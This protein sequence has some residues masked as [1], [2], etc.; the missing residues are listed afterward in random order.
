MRR[1]IFV[2]IVLMS[3]PALAQ[4]SSGTIIVFNLTQDKVVVAAD[5]LAMNDNTG[6]PD[7]SHCKIAT[8]GHQLIF[9]TVGS[10][11]WSGSIRG[12]LIQDWDNTELAQQAVQKKCGRVD[13]TG[14]A[15]QWAKDV[16][17]H[18]DLIDRFDRQRAMNIADVNDGQFTAA[19]FIGKGITAKIVAISYNVNKL[20]DP[21]EIGVAD[22]DGMTNCW[23]CGQLQGKI[24]GAGKHLD[25]A[26]K[27][28]STRKHG[29]RLNVRTPL[30]NA[31]ASTKLAVKIVE[32]TID[33]YGE[34][35]QDVGGAVDAITVTK[36]GRITW[37]SRKENCPE[38]QD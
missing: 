29:D 3:Y 15:T 26:A 13:V 14:T 27:F 19:V 38:N 18:W 16:K 24:C 10:T 9:T 25:V 4:I 36:D 11:A 34:K 33:E 37:N 5:S 31:S 17:S 12:G 7:Y 30:R 1:N 6:I 22:A 35:A 20:I 32:M 28:C 23:P 21:V 8:F 2:L